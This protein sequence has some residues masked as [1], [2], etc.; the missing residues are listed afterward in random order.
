MVKEGLGDGRVWPENRRSWVGPHLQVVR[1]LCGKLVAVSMLN[2]RRSLQSPNPAH[3]LP[4][5]SRDELSQARRS[6]ER[7]RIYGDGEMR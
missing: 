4:A 5:A 1:W 3:I 2:E 7:L 6:V